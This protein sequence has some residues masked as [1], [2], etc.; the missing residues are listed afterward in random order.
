M[1]RA[2]LTPHTHRISLTKA[3]SALD[4]I[5]QRYKLTI[6]YDGSAFHGWQKQ[7]VPSPDDP[8]TRIHL[9]TVQHVVV[10]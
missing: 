3:R 7:H 9:R 6:A 10:H 1:A 8:D 2:F 4:P 5:R